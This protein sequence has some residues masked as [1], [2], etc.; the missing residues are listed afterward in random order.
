MALVQN[1]APLTLNNGGQMQL[2][3]PKVDTMK[4]MFPD[5]ES[6]VLAQ[7]LACNNN[8][9]EAA[10]SILL[11]NSST[12]QDNDEQVARSIQQEQDEEVARSVHR[13]LQD[14]LRLQEDRRRQQQALPAVAAR[15]MTSASTSARAL[16]QRVRAGSTNQ[17]RRETS[18]HAARLLD[19]PIESVAYDM[20][21]L[22][23]DYA[24]PSIMTHGEAPLATSDA[25][26]TRYSA[27]LDRA[28]N[29]NR[30]RVVSRRQSSSPEVAEATIAPLRANGDA[31]SMSSG[32][33]VG[34]LI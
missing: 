27:R 7:L 23:A 13:S 31:D 34:E 17:Q 6:D 4:Q 14:E 22:A 19:E 29:A 3:D 12:P 25:T 8:N 9:V 1:V 28:R 30:E 2:A 26:S 21:P 24:P 10:V 18:T 15:A 11:D 20:S 16:L 5:I 32:P 33:T